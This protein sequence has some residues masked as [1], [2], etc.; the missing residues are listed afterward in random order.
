MSTRTP[1]QITCAPCGASM[2]VT[3]F[4]SIS[5]DRLP[6][7]R[8][9]VLER[10][11][12]S[13]TCTC[14]VTTRVEHPTLFVDMGRGWWIDLAIE[15]RRATFPD[16]ERETR[17]QFAAAFD[18]TKFP[19]AIAAMRDNLRVRVV[20][21]LDELREK[22]LCSEH[23]LED[24]YL[25]ILKLELF[26]ARPELLANGFVRLILDDVTDGALD[27]VGLGPGREIARLRVLRAAH[28]AMAGRRSELAST[29][30]ALFGGCYVNAL[31]YAA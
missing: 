4:D 30:P 16:S 10:S 26:V 12:M 7:A 14:G 5:A 18:T 1:T 20:F 21:G 29:Y 28:D 9:W 17:A 6:D 15:R 13:A 11:L 8:K 23:E 25:E 22:L 27:F 19:P 31:R 24:V 3:L 2:M